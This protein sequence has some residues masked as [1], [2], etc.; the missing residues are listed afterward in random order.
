MRNIKLVKKL[1]YSGLEMSICTDRGCAPIIPVYVCDKDYVPGAAK[2]ERLITTITFSD[3]EVTLYGNRFDYSDYIIVVGKKFLNYSKRSQAYLIYREYLNS[4]SIDLSKYNLPVL[5]GT[6]LE[7]ISE[8]D[9]DTIR[10]AMAEIKF[11]GLRKMLVDGK[12]N[13]LKKKSV[14]SSAKVV[15]KTTK[16]LNDNID[17]FYATGVPQKLFEK[18]IDLTEAD[19]KKILDFVSD[20][21]GMIDAEKPK[22]EIIQKVIKFVKDDKDMTIAKIATV[23]TTSNAIPN[24]LKLKVI[25]YFEDYAQGF[26]IKNILSMI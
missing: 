14:K 19:K 3:E 6:D 12:V 17:G 9:M 21:E 10:D 1:K 24:E 13:K 2:S 16:D 4:A 18:N 22:N 5:E 20:V 25:H 11:G 8:S 26:S 23:I 15:K 7:F